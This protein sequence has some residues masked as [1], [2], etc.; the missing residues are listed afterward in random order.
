MCDGRYRIQALTSDSSLGFS[1]AHSVTERLKNLRRNV[2]WLLS[3]ILPH[4]E[5][6]NID[7]E[8]DQVDEIL[9]TILE[10]NHTQE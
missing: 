5:L 9:Q 7:F 4:L 1:L 3:L 6:R 10:A 8:S 2:S